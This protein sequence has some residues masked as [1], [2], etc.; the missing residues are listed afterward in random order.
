MTTTNS[1]CTTETDGAYFRPEK[2]TCSEIDR[3]GP[4]INNKKL[5]KKEKKCSGKRKAKHPVG[6]C[7]ECCSLVFKGDKGEPGDKGETG[8]QGDQGNTI[9]CIGISW[10]GPA[11]ECL[12]SQ[13]CTEEGS[14]LLESRDG[15]VG[16]CK[17]WR[18]QGGMYK[19]LV[20][21]LDQSLVQTKCEGVVEEPTPLW[22]YDP[23]SCKLFQIVNKTCKLFVGKKGDKI[24]DT[25]MGFVLEAKE[26][27]DGLWEKLPGSLKGA[28]GERGSI[29]KC[30]NVENTG[31]ISEVCEGLSGTT[32]AD[33]PAP[34]TVPE[35]TLFY[36]E[37]S[38]RVFIAAGLS[39]GYAVPVWIWDQNLEDDIGETLVECMDNAFYDP[40]VP[41][42]WKNNMRIIAGCQENDVVIETYSGNKFA[43]TKSPLDILGLS[44]QGNLKGEPGSVGPTGPP[45][46]GFVDQALLEAA[47]SDLGPGTSVRLPINSTYFGN[48]LGLYDTAT[49]LITI[50][51]AMTGPVLI[52]LT[53]NTVLSHSAE[54]TSADTVELAVRRSGAIADWTRQRHGLSPNSE[55]TTLSVVE[56]F[57][58]N[59]GDTFEIQIRNL[60]VSTNVLFNVTGGGALGGGNRLLLEFL[61]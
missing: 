31:S 35:G 13:K 27:D 56:T 47:S 20:T 57:L 7:K 6:K 22:F 58:A 8:P 36:E 41:M 29:I 44:L 18:C 48:V 16:C 28:K 55:R 39:Y 40:S 25:F 5:E 10:I 32:L 43:V 52:K 21:A 33:S 26:G 61:R 19:W 4:E 23:S 51:A 17:L 2:V 50:P 15:D 60:A 54:T 46:N 42:L 59:P 30:V 34:D 37:Q 38:A 53:Y 1:S 45:G 49:D 3:C 9:K 12:M 14:Y 11:V 24:I